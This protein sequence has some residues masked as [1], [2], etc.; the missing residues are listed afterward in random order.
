MTYS[1]T[2]AEL[3]DTGLTGLYTAMPRGENDQPASRKGTVLTQHAEAPEAV[4][5][6]KLDALLPF[7]AGYKLIVRAHLAES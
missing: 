4:R 3:I 1:R 7:Q 5:T 2:F 6:A